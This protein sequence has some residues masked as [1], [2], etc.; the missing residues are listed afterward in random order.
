MKISNEIKIGILA[1]VAIGV[2]IWGVNFILGQNLFSSS[3]TYKVEY[4]DVTGLSKSAPV[5]LRGYRVGVVKDLYLN[6]ENPATVIAELNVDGDIQVPRNTR[7]VLASGGLMGGNVVVLEFNSFCN[8]NDCAKEGDYLAPKKMGLVESMLGVDLTEYANGIKKD[9]PSMLDSLNSSIAN[10]NNDA[11]IAKT[12]RDLQQTTENLRELTGKIDQLVGVST[13][14]FDR[15]LTDVESVTN[16]LKQS[17][18]QITGVLNNASTLT[19]NLAQVNINKPLHQLEETLTQ[20]NGTLSQADGAIGNVS[21]TL[22]SADAALK[23]VDGL[24]TKLNEGEGTIGRLITSDEM[25]RDL[26]KTLKEVGELAK[27]LNEKPYDFIPFKSRRKVLKYRKLD[28]KRKA[29]E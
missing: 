9:F 26:E 18:S 21:N 8:G 2:T 16:N 22:V 11:I 13:H 29:N 14:K 3:K 19:Q 12:L 28:E 23:N 24:V 10:P 15:I 1:V 25:A 27:N 6:P 5:L 4:K 20:I 17:N 7:A